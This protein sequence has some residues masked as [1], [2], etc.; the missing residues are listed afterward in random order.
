MPTTE[1]EIQ[2]NGDDAPQ[3]ESETVP[4]PVAVKRKKSGSKT[5]NKKQKSP[6]DD[7]PVVEDTVEVALLRKLGMSHQTAQAVVAFTEDETNAFSGEYPVIL[8]W[9][10][11]ECYDKQRRQVTCGEC[12]K[13]GV[14]GKFCVLCLA[15]GGLGKNIKGLCI[16][17]EEKHF[18]NH[19][20]APQQ[21]A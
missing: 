8:H 5:S 17:C 21:V 13:K 6:V 11:F 19:K 1:S 2:E 4:Q 20:N 12:N 15:K 16:H 7:V 3:N 9:K 18:D 14:A 10:N